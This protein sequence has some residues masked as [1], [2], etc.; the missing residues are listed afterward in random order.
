MSPKEF[1]KLV[2]NMRDVQKWYFSTRDKSVIHQS[3][4]LERQ[5]DKAIAEIKHGQKELFK[6]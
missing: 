2:A 3:K 4:K 6:S 1:V 5:V